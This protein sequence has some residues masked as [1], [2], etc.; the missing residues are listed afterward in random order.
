MG[1]AQQ[2]AMWEE[3]PRLKP[4]TLFLAGEADRTYRIAARKAANL[5]PRA[6]AGIVPNAGHNAHLENPDAFA[7]RIMDFIG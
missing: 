2:A 6:Q 3:L 4:E 5:C 7:G 1:V